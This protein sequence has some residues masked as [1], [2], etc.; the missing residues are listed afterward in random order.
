MSEMASDVE[1]QQ[2]IYK[3]Y[4]LI[5]KAL[6]IQEDHYAVHKWMSIILNSKATF[7]GT[8]AHIKELYNIKKH[9]LVRYL[10]NNLSIHANINIS[11]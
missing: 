1:A 8:K 10:T 2:L 11:L 5:S 3:G 6:D 7:E 4:D 9:L